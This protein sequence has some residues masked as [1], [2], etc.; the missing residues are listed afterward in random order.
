[1]PSS[2]IARAQTA[3]CTSEL[4]IPRSAVSRHSLQCN[5]QLAGRWAVR[6][7][8]AASPDDARARRWAS[9]SGEQGEGGRVPVQLPD[10]YLPRY[11]GSGTAVTEQSGSDDRRNR[12][13]C[14]ERKAERQRQE[15][16]TAAS[17]LLRGVKDFGERTCQ[18]QVPPAGIGFGRR[19][20]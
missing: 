15:M 14:R 6:S 16:S 12:P 18:S 13:G 19:A 1:M 2:N 17:F 7:L 3:F 20:E 9:P 8:T 4:R 10:Q 5:T 11:R